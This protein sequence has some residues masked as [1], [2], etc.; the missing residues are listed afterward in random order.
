MER[1]IIDECTGWEYELKGEQYYPT[2]RIMKNGVITPT[3]I[4]EDNEPA[5]YHVGIWGQ[6]HLRYI[7]QYNK[8]LYLDLYMSGALN[9]Y[10]ADIDAQA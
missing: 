8:R 10:L 6:R 4:L 2:G 5:E 3:E 1:F 7:R 9:E